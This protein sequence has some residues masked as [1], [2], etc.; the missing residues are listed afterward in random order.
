MFLD[1]SFVTG[2]EMPGDY[3]ACW[4]IRDVDPDKV[5]PVFFDFTN[6][7]A[8]QKARFSGE[9]FPADAPEGF[10]GKAFLDFFQVDRDSGEP[11]GIVALNVEEWEP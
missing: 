8:A 10:S 9:F 5:D 4:D 7:R 11:K 1:G 2:K 6:R 3:D